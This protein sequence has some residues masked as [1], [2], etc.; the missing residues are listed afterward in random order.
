MNIKRTDVASL[1][2]TFLTI[3][4]FPEDEVILNV[5]ALER[6]YT[7]MVGDV[8]D[9][10]E[11]GNQVTKQSIKQIKDKWLKKYLNGQIK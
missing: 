3:D 6:T 1:V 9:E 10:L 11:K 8:M 5:P 2:Y 7:Y 4:A